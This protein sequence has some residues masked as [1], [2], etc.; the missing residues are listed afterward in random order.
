MGTEF[1]RA[2]EIMELYP[3]WAPADVASFKTMMR[4]AFLPRLVSTTPANVQPADPAKGTNGNWLLSV[5]DTL[6]Q[7]GVLL[8]DRSVFDQGIGLWRDRRPAYCYSSPADGA[9]PAVPCGGYIGSAS[10]YAATPTRTADAYGYWGQAGGN[11]PASTP[12]PDGGAATTEWRMLP[13]GNSQETCR[14]LEHVQYGLAALMN[15]AETARIQGLDL[16]REQATRLAAC[17]EFAAL[18]ENQAPRDSSGSPLTYATPVSVA[19]TTPGQEPSLCPNAA[20]KATVVLLNS[21]SLGTYVVQPTWEIGFN[22]LA[23]RLGIS[24]PITKQLITSYRKPPAGWVGITHHMGWETLT[25]GDVG[26]VGLA[27]TLCGP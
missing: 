25:H 20:G 22:A 16:Y 14:D 8:D 1:A 13:D 26:S 18:Y 4:R 7:V 24:M 9:H 12:P 6:I 3:K 15:G 19:V 10:G 27:P 2:A 23:N 5:A 11:T 21:G 17:M